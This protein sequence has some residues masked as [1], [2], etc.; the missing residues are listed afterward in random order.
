MVKV[1]RADFCQLP[2]EFTIKS[3]FDLIKKALQQAGL[4]GRFCF[5][6]GTVADYQSHGHS[7][8]L[9]FI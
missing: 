4:L 8:L 3:N 6:R 7:N 2:A 1:S 9:C 5:D